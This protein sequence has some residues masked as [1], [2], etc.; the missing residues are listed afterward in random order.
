M[1]RQTP[2]TA[3]Q[4]PAEPEKKWFLSDIYKEGWGISGYPEAWTWKAQDPGSLGASPELAGEV[5]DYIRDDILGV[6]EK[7]AAGAN[8]SQVRWHAKYYCRRLRF[9]VACPDSP[10]AGV[11]QDGET[12]KKCNACRERIVAQVEGHFR[13]GPRREGPFSALTGEKQKRLVK[14]CLHVAVL[15]LDEA[16]LFKPEEQVKKHRAEF[17]EALRGAGH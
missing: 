3:P 13:R 11:L 10:A 4:A 1:P 6:Y 17:L 8:L 14:A 12:I 9:A 5:I 2:S 16:E 7:L 15:E